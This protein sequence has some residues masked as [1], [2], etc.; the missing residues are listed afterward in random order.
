MDLI[1]WRDADAERGG[2]DEER[3]LTVK[4]KKQAERVAA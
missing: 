1:L 4:A 2:C 3:R